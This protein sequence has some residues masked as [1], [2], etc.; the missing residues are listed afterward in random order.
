MSFF[1]GGDPH[2]SIEGARSGNSCMPRNPLLRVPETVMRLNPAVQSLLNSSLGRQ[3]LWYFLSQLCN[4][5]LGVAVLGVLTRALTVADFGVYSFVTAVLLFLAMFT[6]AGISTSGARLMALAGSENEQRSRSAALLLASLGAGA[7]LTCCAAIASFLVEPLFGGG[8]GGLLL[9]AA[10]FALF[11]PAQEMIIYMAQGANRIGLLSVFLILPRLLLLPLLL[12]LA[13]RHALSIEAA[14]AATYGSTAVAVMC[15]ALLNRPFTKGIRAQLSLL[16]VE[17]KEF[18]R[19]VY[20]ARIVDGLTTGLDKMLLSYHHGMIPV[21]FYSIAFTMASPIVMLSRAM[22]ASGYRGFA[23]QP[24]IPRKLLTANLLWCSA[25]AV[26]LVIACELLLPLLFTNK[27]VPSLGVLPFLA[28]GIGLM[29]LN[30]P[31]HSFLAAQ[32]QGRT[33]RRLSFATSGLLV[34]LNVILIPLL[35]MTGAALSLIGA[36][37]MNLLLNIA[38]YRKFRRRHREIAH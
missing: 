11:L 24:A 22:T 38:E 18:G 7:A 36:F 32:R 2:I 13:S 21:G 16:R 26:V 29:G 31:F 28:A 34:L 3:S 9:M 19:D 5:A 23:H 14:L 15:V 33:L 12:L 27:Y 8:S 1:P 20:A 30:A 4:G 25:G 10:P 37:L 17:L 35:G 6:D